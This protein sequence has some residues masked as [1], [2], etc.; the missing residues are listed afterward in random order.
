MS[1]V[2]NGRL[3]K[4]RLPEGFSGGPEARN[5]FGSAKM[6]SARLRPMMGFMTRV[7]FVEGLAND[8]LAPLEARRAC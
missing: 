5:V 2:S 3:R 4:R 8:R 1:T 7:G 6:I